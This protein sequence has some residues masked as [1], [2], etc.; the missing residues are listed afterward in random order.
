VIGLVVAVSNITE[1]NDTLRIELAN[2]TA[3]RDALAR[4]QAAVSQ[5]R[6]AA[7]DAF[8]RAHGELVKL[9]AER[10][11]LREALTMCRE[12]LDDRADVIDGEDGPR[13][14]AAMSLLTTVDAALASTPP[15]QER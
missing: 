12:Y 2:L 7:N 14:D 3:E 6:N 4:D 11:R 1:E 10:E 13:P 15:N 8:T 5:E 9:R